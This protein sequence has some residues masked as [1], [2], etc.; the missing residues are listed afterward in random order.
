MAVPDGIIKVLLDKLDSNDKEICIAALKALGD[1][2]CNNSDVAEALEHFAKSDDKEIQ[3]AAI[4]AISRIY[5]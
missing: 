2:R 4:N 3:V 1:T 5:R